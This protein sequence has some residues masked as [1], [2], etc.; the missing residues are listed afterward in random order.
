MNRVMDFIEGALAGLL[1]VALVVGPAL[2]VG[3][4]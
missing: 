2:L 3:R 1:V 4:L